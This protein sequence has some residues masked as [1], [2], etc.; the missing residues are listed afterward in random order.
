[1]LEEIA[2]SSFGFWIAAAVIAAIDSAFLLKPGAFAFSVRA[3]HVRLRVSASPFTLRDKELVCSLVSFPFQ[4]FFVCSA[5]APH[6]TSQQAQSL[7]ARLQRLSGRNA[8]FTFLSMLIALILIA[9]PF[10]SAS[11][12]VACPS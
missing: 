11:R 4:P 12:G 7:L 2:S 8:P 9:G 3:N 10:I 1:M 5:D 6:R